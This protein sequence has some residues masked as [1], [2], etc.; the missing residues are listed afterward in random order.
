MKSAGMD[1]ICVPMH[2]SGRYYI[3][4]VLNDCIETLVSEI[5]LSMCQVER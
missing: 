3:L 1:I 4:S 2:V 5:T